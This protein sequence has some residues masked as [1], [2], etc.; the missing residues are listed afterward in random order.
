VHASTT[1][2]GSLNAGTGSICG[3]AFDDFDAQHRPLIARYYG[4]F[5]RV[6]LTD[7]SI[8]QTYVTPISNTTRGLAYAGG[9]NF[10]QTRDQPDRLFTV[11]PQAGTA[12]PAPSDLGDVFNFLDLARDPTTGTLWMLTDEGTGRLY[13]VNPTTG[14]KTLAQTISPNVGQ[15]VSLAIGSDGRFYVANTGATELT[16]TAI[17]E[18][19]PATG[20]ATL[21]TTTGY[22]GSNFLDDFDYEPVSGKWYGV[23]E[24]R[25]P[26]LGDY[27]LVEINGLPIV[28]EPAS[29]LLGLPALVM[30][31][32]RSRKSA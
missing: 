28:P 3:L 26:V 22:F 27:L 19:D 7:A 9:G 29:A 30:M 13:T 6:S 4:D 2:I 15:C 24:Q 31:L 10:Y 23:I 8:V 21:R 17:Y 32:R 25:M 18:V 1:V 5:V 14:V 16:E 20:N 11:K 12:S